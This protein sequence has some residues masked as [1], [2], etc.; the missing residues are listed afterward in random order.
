MKTS[1]LFL[2]LAL[3]VPWLA[4]S[5]QAAVIPVSAGADLQTAIDQ[6]QAGDTL[7]LAALADLFYRMGEI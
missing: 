5:A 4:A 6:A 7:R 2:A 3:S 1:P